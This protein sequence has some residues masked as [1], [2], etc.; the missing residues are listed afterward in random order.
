[1]PCTNVLTVRWNFR[2]AGADSDRLAGL[3]ARRGSGSRG[4]ALTGHHEILVPLF[5]GGVLAALGPETA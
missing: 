4:Y 1:M 3:K 2:L 5:A